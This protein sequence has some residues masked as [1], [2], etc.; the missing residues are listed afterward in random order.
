MTFKER[1]NTLLGFKEISRP[2]T[3][4]SV[5]AYESGRGSKEISEELKIC[6]PT[7]WKTAEKHLKQLLIG[8]DLA[9]ST[10]ESF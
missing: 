6:H 3:K 9:I 7:V 4:K 8:P 2:F 5:A 10:H 1:V